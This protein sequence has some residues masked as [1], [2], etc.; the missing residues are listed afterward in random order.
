LH[1]RVAVPEAFFL[2][3]VDESEGKVRTQAFIMPQS[4]DENDAPEK[5]LSTI[6]EIETRTGLDFL[7]ELPDEAENALEARRVERMW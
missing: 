6:D 7:S 1:R 3:L 4:A 5:F 2:I